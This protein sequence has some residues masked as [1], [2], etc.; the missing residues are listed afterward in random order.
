MIFLYVAVVGNIH[1]SLLGFRSLLIKQFLVGP[2]IRILYGVD[3]WCVAL[4]ACWQ[5]YSDRDGES[6]PMIPPRNFSHKTLHRTIQAGSLSTRWLTVKII[7]SHCG[8]S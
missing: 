2:L 8:Y 5:E 4:Y 7:P 6:E 3:G 1:T